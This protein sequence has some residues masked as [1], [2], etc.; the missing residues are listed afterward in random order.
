MANSPITLTIFVNADYNRIHFY[1]GVENNANRYVVASYR[2]TS[3][4]AS[5]FEEFSNLLNMYKQKFPQV[6]LSN[7][8]LILSDFLFLTDMI[9]IPNL[10]K[11]AVENSLNLVIGTVY[12]NKDDIE[13]NTFPLSQTKQNGVYGLVGVRKELIKKFNE[14]CKKNGGSVHNITFAANAMANGAMALNQKIKTANC[15]IL[16]IKENCSRFAFVNKGRTLGAYNLPFGHS[17]LYK[18]QLA[19][20]DLLFDHSSAELLVLN[21]KERAKAKQL[22]TLSDNDELNAED[23]ISPVVEAYVAEDDSIEEEIVEV[24]GGRKLPRFMLR[25]TPS[26]ARG[27]VYENF[28]IFVKWALDLI[29]NNPKITAQGSIDTVYVNI[30]REYGFLFDMVNQEKKENGVVFSPVVFE[31]TVPKILE[32][33]GGFHVTQFNSMNNF[34]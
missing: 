7:I 5:F 16:D 2:S 22:T 1:T 4:D 13:Y 29:A 31:G 12:K 28:R 6:S 17:M 25:E 24:R 34:Q 19:A 11:K 26:D 23:E 30:P 14:V 8:S 18:S 15:L 20:E 32:M 27:F 10:G 3:I 33:S 9:T 21:A